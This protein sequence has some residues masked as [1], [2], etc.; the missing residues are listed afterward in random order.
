MGVRLQMLGGRFTLAALIAIASVS[1][2]HAEP[3]RITS[4][5]VILHGDGEATMSVQGAGFAA[6][7]VGQGGHSL[8]SIQLTA[9]TVA[10]LDL[11]TAIHTFLGAA[12]VDGVPMIDEDRPGGFIQLSANLD[13]SVSPF[14]VR[15]VDPTSNLA[16]FTPPFTMSGVMSGRTFDGEGLFSVPVMGKGT[17]NLLLLRQHT[18][19]G[20]TFSSIPSTN[21]IFRFDS[22]DVAPVP[23]P[24]SMLLIGSGL[25][26]LAWRRSRG[27][28]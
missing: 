14:L 11:S 19:S 6:A 13:F 12:T 15:D 21:M 10:N 20:V 28:R 18:Q 5:F 9:E 16:T 24:T 17:A 1:I 2:S 23:E 7:I 25:A 22:A 26:G 8:P 4:G 27:S 3:V